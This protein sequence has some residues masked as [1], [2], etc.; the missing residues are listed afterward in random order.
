MLGRGSSWMRCGARGGLLWWYMCLEGW[1]IVAHAIG[2][3]AGNSSHSVLQSVLPRS[4]LDAAGI[5]WRMRE[6]VRD[7][8][9]VSGKN[10]E[11]RQRK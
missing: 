3:R 9:Q 4:S 2:G 5:C 1:K 8:Y 6:H 10:V 11:G 7:L